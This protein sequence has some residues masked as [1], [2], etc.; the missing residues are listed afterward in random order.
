MYVCMYMYA[1]ISRNKFAFQGGNLALQ[2][3]K[4]YFYDLVIN[5]Q[6]HGLIM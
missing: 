5:S 4:N 1:F 3:H 6:K 2:V